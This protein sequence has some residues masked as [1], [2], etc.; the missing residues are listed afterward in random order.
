MHHRYLLTCLHIVVSFT[1][2][3]DAMDTP[4]ELTFEQHVNIL[5]QDCNT[6]TLTENGCIAL[7][8][9]TPTYS[10]SLLTKN[11]STAAYSTFQQLDLSTIL[12]QAPTKYPQLLEKP[13]EKIDKISNTLKKLTYFRLL[14]GT[15]AQHNTSVTYNA[16]DEFLFNNISDHHLDI[17][18]ESV[19]YKADFVLCV[20]GFCNAEGF[21]KEQNLIADLLEQEICLRNNHNA[22]TGKSAIHEAQVIYK[23]KNQKK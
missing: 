2:S 11:K 8:K 16:G 19:R 7:L 4:K 12:S 14:Q 10:D 21:A 1:A 5:Q 18:K 20:T 6:K 23:S 3:L 22:K 17:T 15:L 9:I 13:Y